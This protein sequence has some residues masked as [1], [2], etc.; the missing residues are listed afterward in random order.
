MSQYYKC[1][2]R[3]SISDYQ[4]EQFPPLPLHTVLRVLMTTTILEPIMERE[5]EE[6]L[7]VQVVWHMNPIL[8]LGSQVAS[9]ARRIMPILG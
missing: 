6:S 3:S 7:M 8:E 9:V 2:I 4:I 1:S 5:R